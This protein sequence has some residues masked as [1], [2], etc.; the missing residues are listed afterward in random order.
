MRSRKFFGL[1]EV[2]RL[3]G[4][5]PHRIHYAVTS[6]HVPEPAMRLGNKRAFGG[7]DVERLARHLGVPEPDSDS[8]GPGGSNPAA[9]VEHPGG[10]ALLAPFGVERVVTAGHEVRGGDGQ[11]YC[12]T[13]DRAKALVIAGLLEAASPRTSGLERKG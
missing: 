5:K 1:G 6:G 11:V 12:W 9:H 2:A 10:M 4:V 8:A 13:T 3:L 7:E